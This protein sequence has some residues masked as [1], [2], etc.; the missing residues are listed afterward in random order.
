MASTQEDEFFGSMLV[1]LCNAPSS[2]TSELVSI[3]DIICLD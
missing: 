1:N 3:V 2:D